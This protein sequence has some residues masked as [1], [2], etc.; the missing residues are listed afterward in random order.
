VAIS[1]V[2][3]IINKPAPTVTVVIAAEHEFD[4]EYGMF[5]KE[6][7]NNLVRELTGNKNA[8]VEFQLLNVDYTSYT[9]QASVLLLSVQLSDPNTLLFILD[10]AVINEMFEGDDAFK[11]LE[12][13]G[14]GDVKR[15]DV[16]NA[17][18]IR[19]LAGGRRVK[20]YAVFMEEDD[21]TSPDMYGMGGLAG[22]LDKENQ[23]CVVSLSLAILD[24]LMSEP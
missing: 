16:S 8:F 11:N 18:R 23:V 6:E 4:E 24:Y 13:Y 5:L 14:Y 20:L 15:I 3:S 12:P 21:L 7:L 22:F 9:G 10:D 2:Y 19:A 1:L 17:P